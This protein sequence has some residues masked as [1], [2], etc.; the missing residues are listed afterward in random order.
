[1]KV[2]MVS[3]RKLGARW[4][5]MN[6]AA[7]KELGLAREHTPAKGEVW[8]LK[9]LHKTGKFKTIE[10][11]IYEY[12]LMRKRGLHYRSADRLATQYERRLRR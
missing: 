7:A 6:P 2:R 11:E 1:M 5:G 4:Q 8:C 3:Q 10:H 9:T 12:A